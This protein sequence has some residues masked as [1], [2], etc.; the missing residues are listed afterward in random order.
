MRI[1]KMLLINRAP[2]EKIHLDFEKNITILS[3]ING[4]G[5]T[6]ILTYIV[7]SFYELAK[8]AFQNEF[9]NKAG[10]YYRVSS[11]LF[12]LDFEAPSVVYIRFQK[13]DGTF[14]D[15]IDAR[16]EIT[17]GWYDKNINLPNSIP[18]N[19]IDGQ[20]QSDNNIKYWSISDKKEIEKLFN[21]S[22]YTYFPAY[23]Y[24]E[25]SFLNDPYKIQLS[26]STDSR[27][28]GYLTNPIEVTSDLPQITNW[29]MDIVLDKYLYK[30]TSQ[31]QS[32]INW[33]LSLMLSPKVGENVRI[34]IGQRNAGA[35]RIAIMSAQVENKQIYPSVF[36]MSSGELSLLCLFGELLRQSDN[37]G[38]NAADVSGIVLIDEIDKH[39]HIRIQKEILPKL[40]N[41][42]PNIQFIVT[43]HSPFFNLGFENMHNSQILNMDNQGIICS[44]QNNQLFQEVYDMLISENQNFL[45]QY[46]E[47]KERVAAGSKP[48]IITEGKTD[49]KHIKN[50]QVKLNIIDCD[51]EYYENEEAFGDTSLVDFLSHYARIR[52][53]R[54][55]IGIFDRDNLPGIKNKIIGIDNQEYVSL[56]N[57]VYAFAI[58][59]VNDNMYGDKT[60]IEHYYE[61]NQ[62]LKQDSQG[63]RLFL[64]REFYDS[65]NS[66]D[67]EWCTKISGIQNKVKVNGIIDEKVYKRT[68][69]E[70]TCSFAMSKSDFAN[71]IYSQDDFA[72]D[73]SF[74]KFEMIFDLIKRIINSDDK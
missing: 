48:L 38:R 65:G 14:A 24:E 72:S 26:F 35:S 10:K 43:S 37:I 46:N 18:F 16:G 41:M 11:P 20:L 39:Q 32:N 40:L 52:Q 8:K 21:N 63:R 58:P 7:D 6:T 4:T 57:N 30:T 42:F 12:S 5:K 70:Q 33:L 69:L 19:H 15:Y 71:H 56:G 44:P 50:A 61:K 53:A 66:K 28:S 51:I 73:F 2:F 55:I 3:G 1:Q 23:R 49:W 22:L 13:N 60:T 36:S 74:E 68:D 9:E 64:G 54:R 45:K 59:I 62:L 29:I 25:P 67:G 17:Q 47:I 31:I 27:F 34:G